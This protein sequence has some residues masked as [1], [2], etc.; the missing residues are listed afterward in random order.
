MLAVLSSCER[1]DDGRDKD[2]PAGASV[3]IA[4]MQPSDVIATVNGVAIRKS[5][6][7][8]LCD[9]QG[10]L[11]RLRT[12]KNQGDKDIRRFVRYQEPR[13]P[14]SLIK[15]EIFRQAAQKCGIAGDDRNLAEKR[16][17]FLLNQNA[18]K[19]KFDDYLKKLGPGRGQLLDRMMREQ[20]LFENLCIHLTTNDFNRVTEKQIDDHLLK[21]AK[22]DERSKR[23]NAAA[24]QK[25]LAFRAE[26][27]NG[28][29]FSSLARKR[30]ELLPEYADE[31][32][33]VQ[34]GEL[35]AGSPLL[36]WLSTAKTG[37][38]SQPI[39]LDDGLA[40]IKVVS[41]TPAEVPEGADPVDDFTLVRCTFYAYQYAIPQTRDE[42]RDMLRDEQREAAFREI[43]I[44]L[45]KESVIAY[46]NGTEFFVKKEKNVKKDKKKRSKRHE[47]KK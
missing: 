26:V 44:R 28:C 32:E 47:G 9:L 19:V 45:F 7:D 13:L 3:P 14:Q 20:V 37:D 12:K 33:T 29:D 41:R 8:A 46:P 10:E 16:R 40:V 30:A 24:M 5:D 2:P 18:G 15:C 43:G 6:F 35:E 36:L 27:T 23:K 34:L 21:I 39:D 17:A 4:K 38:I 31:W 25:A 42:I 1:K 11:Y 22:F